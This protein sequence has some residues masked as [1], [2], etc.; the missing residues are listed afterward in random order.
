MVTYGKMTYNGS[1]SKLSFYRYL[2]NEELRLH[3]MHHIYIALLACI[4]VEFKRRE[5]NLDHDLPEGMK[6]AQVYSRVYP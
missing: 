5:V 6:G 3:F 4:A 1:I 2:V